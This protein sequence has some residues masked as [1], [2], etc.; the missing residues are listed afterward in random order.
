MSNTNPVVAPSSET[1]SVRSKDDILALCVYY[2]KLNERAHAF[3]TVGESAFD[4]DL[5][6]MS[7]VL[8]W[9]AGMSAPDL[10][11][12]VRMIKMAAAAATIDEATRG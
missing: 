10:D 11:Q 6:D 7:Y 12:K 4:V 1:S 2:Q 5:V 3:G 9:A 8:A